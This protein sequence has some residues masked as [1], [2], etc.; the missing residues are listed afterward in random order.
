[1]IKTLVL[2]AAFSLS[3]LLAMAQTPAEQLQRGIFAQ[4]SQGN[5]DAAITIYRQL[6]YS[7]LTP[8][9]VAAEAQYRLGQALLA[10]G[11]VTSAT[12]E[13]ERLERDFADYQKLVANLAT[14]RDHNPLGSVVSGGLVPGLLVEARSSRFD[15]APSVSFQ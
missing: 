5:V 8:R 10:K 12:R 15:G 13:F 9:D 1:M 2:T 7:G 14:R 3:P 11:D 4:D 6:A